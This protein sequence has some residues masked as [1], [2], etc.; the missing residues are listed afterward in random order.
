MLQDLERGRTLE[1]DALLGVVVEMAGLVGIAVPICELV[2]GL[3]RQRAR[4]LGLY[5]R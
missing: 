2:L 1:I 5:G 4:V 3:V